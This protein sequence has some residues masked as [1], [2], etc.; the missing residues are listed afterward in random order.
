[1]IREIFI[2]PGRPGTWETLELI[3][4]L[5]S[6]GASLIPHYIAALPVSSWDS[7]LRGRWVYEARRSVQGVPAQQTFRSVAQQISNL[8]VTGRLHGDCAEA[9][10]IVVAVAIAGGLPYNIIALRPADE[11]EFAHVFVIVNARG[12]F[13]RIDPTAPTDADYTTWEHMIYP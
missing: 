2:R 13:Y 5:G 9:A 7:Q 6:E 3:D 8:Q 10:V 4:R 12:S 1:M 11:T